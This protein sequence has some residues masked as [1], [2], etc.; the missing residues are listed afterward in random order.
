MKVTFWK[1]RL[2]RTWKRTL[3]LWV[4]GYR[5]AAVSVLMG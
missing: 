3:P 4:K 5:P 1:D 2:G